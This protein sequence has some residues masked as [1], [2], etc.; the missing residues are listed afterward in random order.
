MTAARQY[1]PETMK[2]AEFVAKVFSEIPQEKADRIL[3]LANAYLDGVN[4]GLRLSGT[5]LGI[6]R[7]KDRKGDGHVK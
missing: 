2:R 4:T 3:E 1:E 7:K 6:K 5:D